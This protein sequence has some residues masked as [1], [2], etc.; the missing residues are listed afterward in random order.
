M[1]VTVEQLESSGIAVVRVAG[2]GTIHFADELKGALL[3]AFAAAPEVLLDA[4][5]VTEIDAAFLQ[6]I[7][8][9]GKSAAAAN[10]VFLLGEG[11]SEEVARGFAEAGFPIPPGVAG[12]SAATLSGHGGDTK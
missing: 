10:K 6:L 1:D 7:C 12:E 9:A 11:C 2:R 8:A 4:N 5:G 3:E